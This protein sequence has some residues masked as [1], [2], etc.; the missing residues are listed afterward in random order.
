[1]IQVSNLGHSP[2]VGD[3]WRLNLHRIAG[4]EEDREF[5]S[6][7][8]SYAAVPDCLVFGHLIFLGVT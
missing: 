1:M 3:A 4:P 2:E 8:P 5:L 6:W 7:P